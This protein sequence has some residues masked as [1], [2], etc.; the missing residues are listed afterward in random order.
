MGILTYLLVGLP[1]G[2]AGTRRRQRQ[3]PGGEA[4]PAWG[5]S[6]IQSADASVLALF[7]GVI[8]VRHHQRHRD[9]VRQPFRA[10]AP[11]V[12]SITIYLRKPHVEHVSGAR[13]PLR[14]WR[15]GADHAG[16]DEWHIPEPLTGLIGIALIVLSVWSSIRHRKTQAAN[17]STATGQTGQRRRVCRWRDCARRLC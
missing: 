17:W 15:A 9:H 2:A 12:R 13:R 16:V 7:D 4:A 10:L 5:R 1:G 14:D 8:G 11:F 6:R 3:W